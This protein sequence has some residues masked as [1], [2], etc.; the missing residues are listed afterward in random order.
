MKKKVKC[1]TVSDDVANV[2]GDNLTS[3]YI[4]NSLRVYLALVDGSFS[5]SNDFLLI[6]CGDGKFQG[7]KGQSVV[8]LD[9]L[10][11]SN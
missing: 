8:L 10:E 9:D 5:C 7:F 11:R 3:D 6:Q 1:L 2:L 4:N